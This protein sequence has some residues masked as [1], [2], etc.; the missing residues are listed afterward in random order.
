MDLE[1][2]HLRYFVAVAEELHFGRA[3]A[4]LQ[5]AQPPLSQQIRK[6]EIMTGTP[7]FTR[8]TR[9]VALTPAGEAFLVRARHLLAQAEADL[10]EA[11]RIGRGEAGR[12]DIGFI[13]SAVFLG[14]PERIRAFRARF[15]AVELRL[16]EAFSAQIRA[17]LLE[18]NLDLG[19][20]RDADPDPELD[21]RPL[22][23]EEFVAVVPVD[24]PAAGERAITASVL[25]GDPFVFFPAAAGGLAHRRNRQPCHEAGYE[26][27][28]VQEAS[29]WTTILALVGAGLGV[30]IAPL[31]AA[32]DAPASTRVLRLRDTQAR[33]EVNLVRRRTDPRRII[34]DF[35][36]L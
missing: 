2:R 22:A 26:P 27:D 21:S 20:V 35:A 6:L 3:A 11:A 5:M 13:G 28:V 8:T 31:S 9:S 19:V 32:A 15:P 4:R 29:H 25:A 16:H 14:V 34:D 24:H 10:E 18:G 36:G 17:H 33:S 23:T 1:L 7:L 30:T 12:L